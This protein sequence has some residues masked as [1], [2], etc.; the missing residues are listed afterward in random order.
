MRAFAFRRVEFFVYNE[1]SYFTHSFHIHNNDNKRE[2]VKRIFV[3]LQKTS[4]NAFSSRGGVATVWLFKASW[5]TLAARVY[6]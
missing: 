4:D 1:Q 2:K 6:W 5:T 3:I